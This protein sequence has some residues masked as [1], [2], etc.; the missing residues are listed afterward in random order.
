MAYES[1]SKLKNNHIFIFYGIPL[2]MYDK[3]VLFIFI[4]ILIDISFKFKL[5]MQM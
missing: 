4:F 3:N 5:H 1:L 2:K